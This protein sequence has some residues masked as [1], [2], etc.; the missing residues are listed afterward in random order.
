MPAARQTLALLQ[1]L[2]RQPG[3]LPAAALARDLG[4][5]RSTTYALLA[6]RPG[7]CHEPAGR[8]AR[9]RRGGTRRAAPGTDPAAVRRG[10]LN[11]PAVA[12]GRWG[13]PGSSMRVAVAW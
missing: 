1:A 6:R 8:P 9:R 12:S 11:S 4:L 5:P 13:H 7:R 3:P 2:A 10:R